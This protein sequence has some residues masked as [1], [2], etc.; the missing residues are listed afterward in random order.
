MRLLA[1]PA[2]LLILSAA[3]AQQ[4]PAHPGYPPAL[5]PLEPKA[6]LKALSQPRGVAVFVRSYT[7]DPPT[8]APFY[9]SLF[10]SDAILLVIKAEDIF[11]PKP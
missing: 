2:L 6:L 10:R 1:I 3:A 8:P 11:N 7:N 5:K 4:P 9:R